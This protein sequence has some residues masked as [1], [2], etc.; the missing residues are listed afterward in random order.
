MKSTI[1]LVEAIRDQ[2]GSDRKA[3][4]LFGITQASFSRW[5]AG[6]DFPTDDNAVL[7]AELLKL[8]DAYVLAIIRRDRAK[9]KRAKAAWQRVADAFGKAA[10]VAAFTVA[11]LG[12]APEARADLTKNP[13]VDGTDYTLRN[14]KRR[15]WFEATGAPA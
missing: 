2:A 8:D 12:G 9:S 1:E 10:A 3:A 11:A 5:R 15:R 6:D 13:R 4:A 14:K 7:I